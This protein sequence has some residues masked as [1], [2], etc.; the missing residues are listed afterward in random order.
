MIYLYTS[1]NKSEKILHITKKYIYDV[2][3]APVNKVF[4]FYS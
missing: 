2:K 3:V 1:L 4:V